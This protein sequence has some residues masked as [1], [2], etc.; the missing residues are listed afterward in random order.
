MQIKTVFIRLIS[1]IR[2]YWKSGAGG[3]ILTNHPLHSSG[4]GGG[5]LT[6]HPLHPSGAGGVILANHPLHLWSWRGSNPRPN[7]ERLRFLHAYSGLHCREWP[8]PGPPSRSVSSKFS[9][10]ARGCRQTIPDLP[11]P[12]VPQSRDYDLGAMSCRCYLEQ[13]LSQ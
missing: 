2:I 13:R 3:V 7:G 5:I 9:P 1:V 8:R 12:P 4:A 6:N 11:A 10:A